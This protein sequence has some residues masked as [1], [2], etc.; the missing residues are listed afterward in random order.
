M[1]VDVYT[2]ATQ[3]GCF[4]PFEEAE[5]GQL[6]FVSSSYRRLSALSMAQFRLVG[7]PFISTPDC[8]E[9]AHGRQ[10]NPMSSLSQECENVVRRRLIHRDTG[11]PVGRAST[12]TIVRKSPKETV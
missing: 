9:D 3:F 5:T 1:K 12:R 6:A 2:C 7:F 11:F 4:R 8:N 10:L